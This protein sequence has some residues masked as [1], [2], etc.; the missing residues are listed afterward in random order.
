[1]EKGRRGKD[2]AREDEVVLDILLLV[3]N[4]KRVVH[5]SCVSLLMLSD[6]LFPACIYNPFHVIFVK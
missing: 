3:L 4:S 5:S 2:D 6:R 1:V